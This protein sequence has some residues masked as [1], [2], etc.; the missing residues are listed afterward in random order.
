MSNFYTESDDISLYW[1]NRYQEW[2]KNPDWGIFEL[3]D[4]W[5][6]S[7][8]SH[9]IPKRT[10]I[11]MVL[12]VGCGNAMY[13]VPL[14]RRFESYVGLDTSPTA[15]KIA[16]LYFNTDYSDSQRKRLLML[17]NRD[18][19]WFTPMAP[20]FDCVISITVLQ[21]QPIAY[22]LAMIENIKRLLK[23]GGLYIGLE[24]NGAETQAR[25]MP[26]FPKEDWIK[27]WEPMRI[28]QDIPSEHPDWESDH[29][30]VSRK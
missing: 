3:K 19:E 29:V 30:W 24:W 2:L 20:L 13:S 23:P 18:E 5:F 12:E 15:I 26:P 27:A 4:K 10:P 17:I 7:R 1:E 21:H 28:V 9:I 11:G 25:D 14:L 6:E 8:F 22:R 16:D